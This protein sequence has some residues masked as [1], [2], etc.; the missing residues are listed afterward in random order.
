MFHHDGPFDACAPSRNRHRTKAPMLAWS[1]TPNDPII[2]SS[3]K[4]VESSPYPAPEVYKNTFSDNYYEVPKKKV[5]AIA[6]AWGIHEPEPFEDFSAGGGSSRPEGDT[7]NSSIYNGKEG[8]NRSASHAPGPKRS[9]DGRDLREVYREYLDGGVQQSS[10]SGTGNK[11]SP[12]PPP[13]P[14]FVPSADHP[15]LIDGPVSAPLLSP[16]LTPKRNK[17]LMQR[18]RKMRDTPNVPVAGDY[19]TVEPPSPSASNLENS[20]NGYPVAPPVRPI[21]RPQNSFLGRFGGGDRDRNAGG[22]GGWG[23]GKGGGNPKENISP[24]TDSVDR[25]KDLPATPQPRGYGSATPTPLAEHESRG[26]FEDDHQEMSNGYNTSPGPGGIG[27]RSSVLKKVKGV[28][29]TAK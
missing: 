28:V 6:E 4:Y 9:K 24:T 2:P 10:R 12:L 18:I 25:G 3:A 27:R 19:E 15:D 11:R 16:Q 23:G 21:H 29:K 20:T 13:Q 14:I 22:G 17:S 26:Y 1:S 7:P 5:D 8:H